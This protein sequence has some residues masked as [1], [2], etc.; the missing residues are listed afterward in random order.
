MGHF[1][2]E[3]KQRERVVDEDSAAGGCDG[4]QRIVYFAPLEMLVTCERERGASIWDAKQEAR[5]RLLARLPHGRNA[6]HASLIQGTS[7]RMSAEHR[8]RIGATSAAGS[9]PGG[10]G[11]LDVC[12]TVLD[13]VHV[14][15]APSPDGGKAAQQAHGAL[16]T[17]R[18]GAGRLHDGRIVTSGMDRHLCAWAERPPHGLCNALRAPCA[19]LCLVWHAAHG[20]LLSGGTDGAVRVWDPRRPGTSMTDDSVSSGSGHA[21]GAWVH[22]LIVIVTG[23]GL[24]IVLSAGGDCA[25]VEWD[26]RLRR[27][28]LTLEPRRALRHHTRAAHA[29]AFS[30][31]YQL[32]LSA[33]SEPDIFLWPPALPTS[34]EPKRLSGHRRPVTELCASA[35]SAEAVSVD[36]GGSIK[37]W[38]VSSA[39]CLQAIEPPERWQGLQRP[40]VFCPELQAS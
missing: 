26:L 10:K 2:G 6:I 36:V 33:G 34:M 19:Q 17:A 40:L 35:R 13:C 5:M 22:K 7:P 11:L 29:L 18:D 28:V 31:R 8:I 15:G 23:A 12:A 32:L 3:T 1:G 30:A 21:P 14:P 24:G 38:N 16:G 37:I 25:V 39:R 27:G 4:V 9:T 20:A